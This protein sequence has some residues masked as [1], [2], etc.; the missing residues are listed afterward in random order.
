[1]NENIDINKL[2]EIVDSMMDMLQDLVNAGVFPVLMLKWLVM[3]VENG[4]SI[5]L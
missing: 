5:S 1:M 2:R 4:E 3:M